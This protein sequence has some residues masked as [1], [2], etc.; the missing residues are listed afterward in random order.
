MDWSEIFG[1]INTKLRTYPTRFDNYLQQVLLNVFLIFFRKLIH[2]A[3]I[4]WFPS[5]KDL[6]VILMTISKKLYLIF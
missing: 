5:K 4:I 3:K 2:L 6:V 1:H